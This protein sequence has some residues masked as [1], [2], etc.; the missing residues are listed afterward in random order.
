MLFE[1][2]IVKRR[3]GCGYN[4]SDEETLWSNVWYC[5]DGWNVWTE[6]LEEADAE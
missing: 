3:V 5:T 2:V 1:K 4:A 6:E